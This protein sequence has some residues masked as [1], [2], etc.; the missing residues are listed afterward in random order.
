[1]EKGPSKSITI[2]RPKGFHEQQC[3]FI[4]HRT[5]DGVQ[6]SLMF[7]D[8]ILRRGVIWQWPKANKLLYSFSDSHDYFLI[9]SGNSLR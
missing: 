3:L 1:M 5:L 9:K 7:S 6:V 4:G 8:D 2:V